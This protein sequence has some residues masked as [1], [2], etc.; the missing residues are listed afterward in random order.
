MA[1]L[2]LLAGNAKS[3]D[4][5]TGADTTALEELKKEA[6]NHE[7]LIE[8]RGKNEMLQELS[9]KLSKYLSPQVYESIF[10]GDQD[11][12]LTSKRKKLTS[13]YYIFLV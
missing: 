10:S 6:K 11:V 3:I 4:A 5:K 12:T 13:R 8:E 9:R 1:V 7:N 2:L